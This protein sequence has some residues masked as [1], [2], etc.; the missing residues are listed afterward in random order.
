MEVLAKNTRT[1]SKTLMAAY[2]ETQFDVYGGA[3]HLRRFHSISDSVSNEITMYK[4]YWLFINGLFR[5]GDSETKMKNY[6][7]IHGYDPDF[8]FTLYRNYFNEQHFSTNPISN[9]LLML[10]SI[11]KKM[12]KCELK[13]LDYWVFFQIQQLSKLH[14][15]LKD[16]VGILIKTYEGTLLQV[17]HK[18]PAPMPIVNTL[19]IK[20]NLL[21]VVR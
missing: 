16:E 9:D 19:N 11:D 15:M 20:N 14:K 18:Q 7:Q 4:A 8:I 2:A 17:T 5:I 13:K 12:G 1:M 21:R 3:H 10:K 6:L